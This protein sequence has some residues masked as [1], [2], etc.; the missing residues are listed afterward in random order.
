[1]LGRYITSIVRH[2][3]QRPHFRLPTQRRWNRLGCRFLVPCC[4]HPSPVDPPT[5]LSEF[6][7]GA[8]ASRLP[9][10]AVPLSLHPPH[11]TAESPS[12]RS[13]NVTLSVRERETYSAASNCT[14]FSLLLLPSKTFSIAAPVL[15][16]FT[17]RFSLPRPF[18]R[19]CRF[20]G[21]TLFYRCQNATKALRSAIVSRKHRPLP[22][23]RHPAYQCRAVTIS[24][25]S[26]IVDPEV[27][28]APRRPGSTTLRGHQDMPGSPQIQPPSSILAKVPW[29]VAAQIYPSPCPPGL[30]QA[31][32]WWPRLPRASH[33][34]APIILQLPGHYSFKMLKFALKIT[35]NAP[36]CF[37]LTKP[38]SG[39]L[40]S[41][42]RSSHNIGVS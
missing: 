42:P 33:L 24:K 21:T 16:S 8:P 12:P 41:V 39:S 25:Y 13:L 7:P 27:S 29:L 30:S 6:C 1:M 2:H 15:V 11:A 40:Q 19:R 26:S 18:S 9:L 28:L 34:I 4:A 36:T 31:Q 38:S 20:L 10:F 37:G 17:S 32:H 35:I 23:V 5:A 22:S 3:S 14:N